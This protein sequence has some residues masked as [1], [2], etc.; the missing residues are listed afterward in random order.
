MWSVPDHNETCMSTFVPPN[1]ATTQA[2]PRKC[3]TV[4]TSFWGKCRQVWVRVRMTVEQ[5]LARQIALF[6]AVGNTVEHGNSTAIP[7]AGVLY[8]CPRNTTLGERWQ[9][10]KLRIIPLSTSD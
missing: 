3:I 7:L 9:V 5:L 4:T 1:A 8:G 2:K 10:P 6:R